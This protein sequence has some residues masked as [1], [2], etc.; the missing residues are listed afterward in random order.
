V[1]KLNVELFEH[2]D[3]SENV[4]RVPGRHFAGY[5]IA[6]DA[7]H[8]LLQQAHEL[9]SR[10][11]QGSDAMLTDECRRLE[12]RINYMMKSYEAALI[13]EGEAFPYSKQLWEI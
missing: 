2:S 9:T 12:G 6:G 1:K 7:L 4:L 11:M 13:A 5:L 10:S 8:A 3:K